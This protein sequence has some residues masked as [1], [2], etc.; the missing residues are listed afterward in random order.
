MNQLN[1][2]VALVMAVSRDIDRA[3][4]EQL[5]PLGA[6]VVVKDASIAQRARECVPAIEDVGGRAIAVKG[7]LGE[8]CRVKIVPRA[9]SG[10][11][12]TK[13][14]RKEV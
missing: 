5:W 4:A 13:C 1:G 11:A 14:K 8:R 7:R 3:I 12:C 9:R 10:A 6:S 2:K